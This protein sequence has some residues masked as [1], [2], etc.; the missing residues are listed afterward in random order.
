[1]KTI[2]LKYFMR[3]AVIALLCLPAVKVSSQDTLQ[4]REYRHPAVRSVPDSTVARLKSEK[5]FLYA[6]DP[7][8]WKKKERPRKSPFERFLESL[9][10]S[11]FLK[12]LLYFFVAAVIL[13]VL[14]QVIVVNNFFTSSRKKRRKES[15]AGES[16]VYSPETIDDKISDA[17]AQ[18]EFRPAVRYMYLKTLHLLSDKQLISLH[19]K[20]TNEEYIRQMQHQSGGA[21]FRMLTRIYEYV[22]YGEF[23]PTENQFGYIRSSFNRFISKY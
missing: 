8:Y 3:A 2:A 14:Y 9:A 18:G 11:A 12:W 15:G 20:S 7:S 10:R 5:E 4:P 23:Q 22:W 17:I 19:G 21:D 13:F 1:M 6:N 16:E